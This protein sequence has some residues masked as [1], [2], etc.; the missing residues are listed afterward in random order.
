MRPATAKTF[1]IIITAGITGALIR[2]FDPQ[3]W[4][5]I[6]AVLAYAWVIIP[7]WFAYA[8]LDG[9]LMEWFGQRDENGNAEEYIDPTTRRL[10]NIE[11][12]INRLHRYVQEIDPDLAEGR[13]LEREFERGDSVF[14]GANLS[15][16]EDERR[17]L[18]RRTKWSNSIWRK[19]A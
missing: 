19:P 18:G 13:R 3:G 9:F 11:A 5:P 6:G 8:V 2:T 4:K 12:A 15:A 16:Y 1:S 10:D 14:A 7:A 17:K